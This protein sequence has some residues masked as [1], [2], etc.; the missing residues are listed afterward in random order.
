MSYPHERLCIY[1][2]CPLFTQ[3]CSA[4]LGFARLCSALLGIAWLCSALPGSA[5]HCPVLLCSACALNV[6][7]ADPSAGLWMAIRTGGDGA[8]LVSLFFLGEWGG[9]GRGGGERSLRPRLW[10]NDKIDWDADSSRGRADVILQ[11]T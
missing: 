4:L 3:L 6:L 1:N 8:L 10:S 7:P 11:R 2:L 5:R 9:V